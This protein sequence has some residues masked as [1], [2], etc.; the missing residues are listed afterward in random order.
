MAKRIKCRYKADDGFDFDFSN[1]LDLGQGQGMSTPDTPFM[2]EMGIKAMGAGLS[3][4]SG[5]FGSGNETAN[6]IGGAISKVGGMLPGPAGAALGGVG[7]LAQGIGALAQHIKEQKRDPRYDMKLP[8]EYNNI[9]AM[10]HNVGASPYAAYGKKFAM[11]GYPVEAE[12]GEQLLL[13]N[14]GQVPIGG[15]K[16]KDGGT[17]ISND[18]AQIS[19]YIFSDRLG[20]NKDGDIETN[21]KKVKVTFADKAKQIESKFQRSD[22]GK[23]AEAAK[24]L[25]QESLKQD[26]EMARIQKE[27]FAPNAMAKNGGSFGDYNTSYVDKYYGVHKYDLGGGLDN[28]QFNGVFPI[29]AG[30]FQQPYNPTLGVTGTLPYRADYNAMQDGRNDA[31]LLSNAQMWNDQAQTYLQMAQGNY[32]HPKFGNVNALPNA[33]TSNTLNAGGAGIMRPVGGN[34]VPG[35]GPSYGITADPNAGVTPTTTPTTTATTGGGGGT[36]IGPD[37]YVKG[38]GIPERWATAFPNTPFPIREF[39]GHA[40]IKTDGIYGKNT[41][42]ALTTPH[43]IGKWSG[44]LLGSF[45]FSKL[46]EAGKLPKG[47]ELS[48]EGFPDSIKDT[49][50]AGLTKL[51]VDGTRFGSPTINNKATLTQGDKLQ[52]AGMVPG[53][54][55][56]MIKGMQSP[57]HIPAQYNQ[58]KDQIRS[59]MASRRF[60]IQ[61]YINES[62]RAYNTAIDQLTNNS[63]SSATRNANINKAYANQ[64]NQLSKLRA[65]EDEVNNRYRGEE[66]STLNSLGVQ[67]VAARNLREQLQVQTDAAAQNFQRA[68]FTQMGQGLNQF[69]AT[70]NAAL[71]NAMFADSLNNLV[72]E[73]GIGAIQEYLKNMQSGG[74]G[75]KYTG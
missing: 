1:Q 13:K 52:L 29:G 9:S 36:T 63:S 4:A 69:G 47:A 60:D 50:A 2:S 14:G 31:N 72:G 41:H 53:M 74:T 44:D 27:G 34:M 21:T 59:I 5:L 65:T 3:A 42:G 11:G 7:F 22:K 24:M 26:S 35:T 75:I 33:P 18:I 45:I 23:G 49:I 25:M 68:A 48:G 28:T 56:N 37:S 12:L 55:Y 39:Q 51:P 43:H 16:H 17:P 62:N 64:I 66:A 8:S 70:K 61:P 30:V 6:K 38:Y 54:L 46:H 32:I 40:G 20:Y 73:F 67:D 15:K 10:T 19:D 57:D 58:Y 71:T